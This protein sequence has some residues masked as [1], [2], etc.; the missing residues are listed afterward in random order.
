MWGVF[1]FSFNNDCVRKNNLINF[2]KT[3]LQNTVNFPYI[4]WGYFSP[5]SNLYVKV[6]VKGV[7]VNEIVD[8]KIIKTK[9]YT[10]Q[11]YFSHKQKCKEIKI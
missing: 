11:I 9:Q 5:K 7:D 2:S 8:K 6:R 10:K 1:L 4:V 3:P